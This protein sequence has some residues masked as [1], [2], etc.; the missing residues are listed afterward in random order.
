MDGPLGSGDLMEL[1]QLGPARPER[2]AFHAR[3]S[4]LPCGT[5]ATSSTPYSKAISCSTT[6]I[7]SFTPVVD[8][9]RTAAADQ[10]V[11]AIKQTLY[12]VGSHSPIVEAL[13]E[14]AEAGK[15]V[16]VLVEA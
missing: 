14:A 4:R 16:A 7:D 9:I 11:L 10:D 6:L 2:P 3:A 8:F 12:R 5:A 1:T 13:L 15:Q